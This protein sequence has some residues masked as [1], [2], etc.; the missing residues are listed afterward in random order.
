M[1]AR[2]SSPKICTHPP[3]NKGPKV[4]NVLAI[5]EKSAIT[6]VASHGASSP[7]SNFHIKLAQRRLCEECNTPFGLPVVP[8]VYN[9]NAGISG[10][11][12]SAG[13]ASTDFKSVLSRNRRWALPI[14]SSPF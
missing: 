2:T 13:E 3:Q 14:F 10:L 9:N 6:A 12:K 8:D 5:N 11:L 4:S 7:S 1:S